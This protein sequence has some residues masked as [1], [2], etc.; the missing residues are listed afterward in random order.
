MKKIIFA[1]IIAVGCFPVPTF[2]QTAPLPSDKKAPDQKFQG[3]NLEGYTQDGQKSWD[4]K[5]DT[6]DVAGTQIKIKNVDAN[7]YGEQKMNVTAEKGV[8]DQKSGDLKLEKDVTITSQAGTQMV[9]DS[10]N[11]NRQKD[12]VTT[13][14]KVTI[15][16]D[17]MLVTGKGMEAHPG[18][19]T[20]E[21][22]KDVTATVTT[23]APEGTT[24]D[25][26]KVVI[27]SDGPMVVDQA[28][29][30]A[31]F[32]ENVTAIQEGRTLRSDNMEVYFNPDMKGVDRI[33]CLGHVVIEQ[34]EN[35][36]FA[37]KATYDG[38]TRKLT[39]SGRPK[40]IL[41]TE[42]ENGIASFRDQESR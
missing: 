13:P 11:W 29:S 30:M 20:A 3:F 41:V 14:D 16:D 19:K 33:I 28:R 34:G 6:A 42:G 32:K 5:G 1:I 18:L 35:K 10:L 31:M 2:A 23:T 21:I 12:L 27:T 36:T 40:L 37:D 7:A 39:L 8:V 25:S 17:K 26:N 4:V 22:Q 15:S 9:T 24:A 38:K